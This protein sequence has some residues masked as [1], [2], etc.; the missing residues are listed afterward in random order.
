VAGLGSLGRE[1]FVAITEF[2]G[3]KI[4]REAK[5][6][7]PSAVF[8][9]S[10]R[11]APTEICYQ[12]LL[13][14]AVRC[15]DPFVHLRDRWVVRRLSPHCSRIDLA[16]LPRNRD[17]RR[18]LFSM[19]WETANV[20]LGNREAIKNTRKHLKERK[21]NWLYAAARQ[22]ANAVNEDWQAW[23]KARVS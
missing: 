22:M 9:V 19:G 8:W 21:A 15:P 16:V 14:R 17:E 12:Q 4:A 6:L 23:K 1:R 11:L 13:S 3:G 2:H 20:H 10:D 18:L 7:V 5:Q